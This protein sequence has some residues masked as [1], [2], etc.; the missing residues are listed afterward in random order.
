VLFILFIVADIIIYIFK[1]VYIVYTSIKI[2]SLSK[3]LQDPFTTLPPEI[4]YIIASFLEEDVDDLLHLGL[5]SPAFRTKIV[6]HRDLNRF[7]SSFLLQGSD[8]GLQHPAYNMMNIRAEMAV[9]PPDNSVFEAAFNAII[10]RRFAAERLRNGD[11]VVVL[12]PDLR[13]AEHFSW[14]VELQG[15]SGFEVVCTSIWSPHLRNDNAVTI[16]ITDKPNNFLPRPRLAIFLAPAGAKSVRKIL[17]LGPAVI[18]I[19]W[20][21]DDIVGKNF[22]DV[23]RLFW[24]YDRR[25]QPLEV[26]IHTPV[27][28]VFPEGMSFKLA[29]V[30]WL[31]QYV[32]I[33]RGPQR[34]LWF[35]VVA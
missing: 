15:V 6:L 12:A 34:S 10:C 21:L 24:L 2:M 30:R 29:V 4:L 16:F 28:K 9:T 1:I 14:F 27:V 20:P 31:A 32:L 26:A 7:K 22:T 35:G 17:H 33:R 19:V 11:I 25:N 18:T 23:K 5:A 8:D 3:E 13:R